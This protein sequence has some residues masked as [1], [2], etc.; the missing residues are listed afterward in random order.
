MDGKP[1]RLRGH[2]KAHGTALGRRGIVSTDQRGFSWTLLAATRWSANAHDLI[3]LTKTLMDTLDGVGSPIN[4]GVSRTAPS[5]AHDSWTVR[6]L[7]FLIGDY[8]L[9]THWRRRSVLE[10]RCHMQR[11]VGRVILDGSVFP[12]L[13]IR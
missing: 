6:T 11:P 2:C 9:H 1:H 12:F 3:R 7:P 8:P 4:T 13:N 10:S 5:W